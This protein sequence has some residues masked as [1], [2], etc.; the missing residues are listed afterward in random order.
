MKQ[1]YLYDHAHDWKT[2]GVAGV[3]IDPVALKAGVV[4]RLTHA[5]H[6]IV[7]LDTPNLDELEAGKGLEKA[8]FDQIVLCVT[9]DP[10]DHPGYDSAKRLHRWVRSEE[11][12]VG[13]EC[14]SRW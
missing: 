6:A 7:H 4:T 11:R 10:R 3:H 5:S 2:S 8:T 1:L 9:T 13:K 14:R 12:R